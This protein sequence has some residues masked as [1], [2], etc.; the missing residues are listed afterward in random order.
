MLCKR[1]P[2]LVKHGKH[3]ETTN[4]IEFSHICGL[5]MKAELV[6][7]GLAADSTG[8]AGKKPARGSLK[9][10]RKAPVLSGKPCSHFPFPNIFDYFE[11][12]TYQETF[13][14]S[15]RKNNVVPSSDTFGSGSITDME[16]L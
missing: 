16:L 1:C 5:V 7:Q 3:N 10:T 15:N 8:K 13:K 4:A 11:C 9:A 2:H 12:Q 14:S 6:E